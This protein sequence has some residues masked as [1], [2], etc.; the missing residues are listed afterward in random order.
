MKNI[1]I[2]VNGKLY[3]LQHPGTRAWL[4]L[5]QEVMVIDGKNVKFNLVDLMDYCFEH[6]VIPDAGDKLKLDDIEINE[7]EEVWSVVLPQFLRG[8]LK[9]NY[10]YPEK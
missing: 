5:K 3:T 6:V 1:E 10:E 2:L 7:I 4:Q 9:E 8:E